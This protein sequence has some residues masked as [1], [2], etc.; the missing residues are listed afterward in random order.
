MKKRLSVLF[1]ICMAL[2][3]SLTVP[4]AAAHSSSSQKMLPAVRWEEEAEPLQ[5]HTVTPDDLSVQD[6]LDALAEECAF[7]AEQKAALAETIPE[8]EGYLKRCD[9]AVLLWNA[10]LEQGEEPLPEEKTQGAP[11]RIPDYDAIPDY[12]REAVA[13]VCGRGVLMEALPENGER[14]RVFHP[15]DRMTREEADTV[16]ARLADASL[17][18]PCSLED[19]NPYRLPDAPNGS[20]PMA[21]WLQREGYLNGV[22]Q[23][24]KFRELFF[25]DRSVTQFYPDTPLGNYAT[26]VTLNVWQV[27][28]NGEKFP[29]TYKLWVHKLLAADIYDIFQQIFEDE[30][31]FPIYLMGCGGFGDELCHAW[32]AAIDINSGYNALENNALGRVVVAAGQGWWPAGT[33]KTEW[34]GFLTEESIYSI[35]ADG[36]V[37]KAFK[38]YGWHWGGDWNEAYRDFMHFSIL[39]DGG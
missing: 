36:S 9:A 35:P 31:H 7:S 26:L 12:A 28:K 5:A 13:E 27:D 4:A 34:A 25:G 11:W 3:V 2:S 16:L 37:V 10:M 21:I 20:V 32:L 24:D 6:F 8:C 17:R 15:G 1:I 22:E 23:T 38:D 14:D 30:E 29:G 18:M 39:P 33:A 19:N